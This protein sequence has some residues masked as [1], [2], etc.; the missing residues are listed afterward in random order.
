[1]GAE[2]NASGDYEFVEIKTDGVHTANMHV[3]M[4]TPARRFVVGGAA[5]S[6]AI[7]VIAG[8][9][10]S[11]PRAE[12]LSIVCNFVP[13]EKDE[14]HVDVARRLLGACVNLKFLELSVEPG[15]YTPD[16]KALIEAWHEA[17]PGVG[18]EVNAIVD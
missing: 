12:E 6:S 14:T 13:T 2:A 15:S 9:L 8:R 17:N 7:H 3:V 10:P 11:N 1:M 16:V 5:G 18:F 4:Q